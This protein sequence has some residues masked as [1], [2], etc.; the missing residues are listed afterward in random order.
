MKVIICHPQ[1]NALVD[2][3]LGRINFSHEIFGDSENLTECR[4]LVSMQVAAY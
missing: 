3:G 2:T 1:S 4:N